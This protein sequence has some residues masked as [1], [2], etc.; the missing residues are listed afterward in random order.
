MLL[1]LLVSVNTFLIYMPT[2]ILFM[3]KL[4]CIQN[5]QGPTRFVN[6]VNTAVQTFILQ[7]VGTFIIYQPVRTKFHFTR[8][9]N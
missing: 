1:L 3:I 8:Y 5:F 2:L 9:K 6:S 7:F 4:S